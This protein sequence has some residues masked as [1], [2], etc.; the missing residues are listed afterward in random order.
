MSR[1][2]LLDLYSLDPDDLAALWALQSRYVRGFAE[3]S[4]WI[5]QTQREQLTITDALCRALGRLT[6]SESCRAWFAAHPL[7]S[8]AGPHTE[9]LLTPRSEVIAAL[10]QLRWRDIRR[11]PNDRRPHHD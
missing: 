7:G 5:P 9:T 6:L 4:G 11:T 2:T 8:G 10:K 3:G 1:R